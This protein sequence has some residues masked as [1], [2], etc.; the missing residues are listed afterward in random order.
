[1]NAYLAVLG[2]PRRG[3]IGGDEMSNRSPLGEKYN[4]ESWKRAGS[5]IGRRLRVLC[6]D[7]VGEAGITGL[8]S[9][10]TLGLRGVLDVSAVLS[11]VAASLT[12]DPTFFATSA[13]FCAL[14]ACC[15]AK[16]CNE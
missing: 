6:A 10:F 3:D 5:R 9:D 4:A 13:P 1:M 16:S 14:A 15:E 8:G 7:S 2:R 11:F 12:T